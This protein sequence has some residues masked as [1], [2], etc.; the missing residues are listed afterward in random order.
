VLKQIRGLHH[1]T[2]MAADAR[3]NNR[4]F[5][6]TLGLRR[7]KK[8]VNF[9]EPSVYHLYYG[10]EV[11]TPGSVMTYFPFP[12][13]GR[14]KPGVGEVGE[15][16]FSVP[17]GA[18][19]YWAERLAERGVEGLSTDSAFG[20]ERLRF[21]GPDGDGFAFVETPEDG[22][23]PWTGGGIPEDA[24]IR[25]FTGARLRLHDTEATAE[26]FLTV[27][28]EGAELMG[29]RRPPKSPPRAAPAPSLLTLLPMLPVT[30]GNAEATRQILL[31]SYL[32]LAIVLLSTVGLQAGWLYVVVSLGLTVGWLRYA[33]R[34]RRT[35]TVADAMRL[36][37][38]STIYIALVFIVAAVDAVLVAN[39]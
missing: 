27:H 38:Y 11:G 8:T 24:A 22:R 2:S 10:D 14:G 29:D 15:T 18:L 28:G 35:R 4:F 3:E 34:L 21:E 37:H 25:G 33:H 26:L 1:I 12:E 20:A 31:S 32:L 19:P 6:D 9:D 13:I 30:H 23:A 39:L 7:V 17:K 16:Q 5:T 36:F